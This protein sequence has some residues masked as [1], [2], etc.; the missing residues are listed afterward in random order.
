MLTAFMLAR[1]LR[2]WLATAV[3][4]GLSL[5]I[6]ACQKVPLL[7]PSGST[8]TLTAGSTALSVNGT[9][10][11][12]AQVLEAAGT[13][14]QDGT[15]VIFTT[16]LGSIEPLEARTNGGRVTVKFRAG[17][18]N[19]TAIITASSGGASASGANAARVAV[20]TAAVGSVRVS[21]N[22]TLLPS[23]GGL[24]TIT[25]TV[26]DIN[27]NPLSSAPV[28]FS[29]T[30]GTLEQVAVSTDANGLA[31]AVLRTTTAATVTVGVGAQAPA[32]APTPPATPGAPTTP[33]PTPAPATTGTASGSVTVNITGTP[34]LLITAP[35][36]GL[37][38]GLPAAFTFAVTAATTNGNP[39][40]DV[41]VEWGDGQSQNLGATT[42][43][44][45]VSH[46]YRSSGSFVV[47]GKVTD[48][49]GNQVTT[50]T[51]VTVNPK[52][53]PAV[54]ITV[55]TANP[56]AGVDMV[57][58]ASIAPVANT[59]TV[60]QSA[61]IDFG[62]GT[63]TALGAVTGTAIAL[64]HVYQNGGQ[65]YPVTLTATDSNGGVGTAFTTVFVQAATPLAVQLSATS[66]P[67][68]ANTTETFTATVV[69]LGNSVVVNYHWVF[70]STL[71][72]TDTP[73]NT[74]T[75]TYAAGSGTITVTVTVTTSTGA[76]AS[77]S[78]VI[79]VP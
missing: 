64:H 47:V 43:T 38:A 51:S 57:F 12:I 15:V 72:T 69:G 59:G 46:V 2:R 75:R 33:T 48:T 24:A 73:S 5:T 45:T 66:T 71:G 7:A 39:I 52:P 6:G 53:Q 44:V 70:G 36:A 65:S 78:T 32:P 63:T 55:T 40:R 62:D 9:T 56:T 29:T 23:T 18:A 14:P 25:G 19:G 41:T 17:T 16:T 37:T 58:T 1:P 77:G 60:I 8:I 31:T 61:S 34:A 20:G 67:S 13:P 30:A 28:T 35:A 79:V 21:A 11:I 3:F 74:Q 68:G 22:P 76:Q 4:A 54:S 27:G 26:V 10:D 50:S 49:A 42:G